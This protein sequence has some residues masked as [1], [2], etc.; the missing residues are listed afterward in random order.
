MR[1]ASFV[2]KLAPIGIFALSASAAGTLD[3]QSLSRLQVYL[4]VYA[5]AWV[6]L[7]FFVLPLFVAWATP[8]SYREAM[9]DAR[10]AMVTA[11]AAGTVLVVILGSSSLPS[12]SWIRHCT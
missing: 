4:W 3:V 10:T 5:A 2:A 1:I 12:G 9:R 8:F 6:V 7:T 11:F